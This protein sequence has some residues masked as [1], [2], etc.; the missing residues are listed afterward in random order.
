MFINITTKEI[1][2]EVPAVTEDTFAP[3][4]LILVPFDDDR[5]YD[6]NPTVNLIEGEVYQQ[7][8]LEFFNWYADGIKQIMRPDYVTTD[9]VMIDTEH[10]TKADF[11][12]HGVYVCFQSDPADTTGMTIFPFEQYTQHDGYVT[13]TYYKAKHV[14]TVKAEQIE[15]INIEKAEALTGGFDSLG[16]T[17]DSDDST[18]LSI[19]ALF[20]MAN[21]NPA[22]TTP[23]ITKDNQTIQL[24]NADIKT[25]GADAL[26]FKA[27]VIFDARAKKDLIL[28][29]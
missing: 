28:N 29:V 2:E 22:F 26:A 7:E 24:S 25:L 17:F 4:E 14:D 15:K 1:V 5:Y 3:Y 19:S 23:F 20:M 9:E 16:Y 21:V 13:W 27:G 6:K 12:A 11:N 10:F 18:L 8:Y